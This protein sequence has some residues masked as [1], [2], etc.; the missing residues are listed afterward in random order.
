[1][2]RRWKRES[3]RRSRRPAT[4]EEDAERLAMRV[5]DYHLKARV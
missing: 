5:R 2:K 3:G 1:M 4:L